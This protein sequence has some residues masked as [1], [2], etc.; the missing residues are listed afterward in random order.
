[1]LSVSTSFGARVRGIAN[2]NRGGFFAV[3][4]TKEEAPGNALASSVY[5]G[6]LSVSTSFGAPI[7]GIANRNREGFFAY[8]TP[9]NLDR[10]FRWG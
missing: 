2:R 3:L 4:G 5:I 8:N 1:M 7:R 6:M 9:Q 10:G